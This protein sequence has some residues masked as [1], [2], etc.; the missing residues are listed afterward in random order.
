[1]GI[2]RGIGNRRGDV[3]L[4]PSGPLADAHELGRTVFERAST[5][6]RIDTVRPGSTWATLGT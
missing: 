3:R 1:M 6:H 4:D 5:D 2:V